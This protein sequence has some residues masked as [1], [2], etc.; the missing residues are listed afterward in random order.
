MDPAAMETSGA[1]A[2][3]LLLSDWVMKDGPRG[4]LGADLDWPL[5]GL[6]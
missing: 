4:R 2:N 3:A 1:L 5:A 6:I